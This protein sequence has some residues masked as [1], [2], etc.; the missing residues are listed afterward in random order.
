[1]TDGKGRGEGRVDRGGRHGDRRSGRGRGVDDDR[2]RRAVGL[3]EPR[4]MSG[5]EP[6]EPDLVFLLE[7]DG[8][9]VDGRFG[10]APAAAAESTIRSSRD[11]RVKWA[12]RRVR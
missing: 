3:A 10:R 12:F 5:L 7:E 1:M 4:R 2:G 11:S 9:R 6:G 8:L